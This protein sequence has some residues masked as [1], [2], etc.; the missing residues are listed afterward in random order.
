[1]N[2]RK[3]RGYAAL[4]LML[5]LGGILTAE[6]ASATTAMICSSGAIVPSCTDEE[7]LVFQCTEG[8]TKPLCLPTGCGWDPYHS[9][10]V[11]E[12]NQD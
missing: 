12:C 10:W 6:E 7:Y 5:S 11:V 4:V 8:Y 1:M 2:L 3:V 9:A